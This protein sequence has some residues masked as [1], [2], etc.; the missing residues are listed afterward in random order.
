MIDQALNIIVVIVLILAGLALIRT[1]FG[2]TANDRLA[3]INLFTTYI[4]A[5][6]L[7]FSYQ[8]HNWDYIDI[9]LVFVLANSV[10][11]V[12]IVKFF[13]QRTLL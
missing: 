6:F 3:A 12:A 5:L 2:P 10:A 1:F 7:L 4:V 11:T 8:Q 13:R 9:A